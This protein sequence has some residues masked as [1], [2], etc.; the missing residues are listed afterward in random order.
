MQFLSL[1]GKANIFKAKAYYLLE[2]L[3]KLVKTDESTKPCVVLVALYVVCHF[4]C[5]LWPLAGV[6]M[7]HDLTDAHGQ[8][9]SGKDG[10]WI[11]KKENCP[12]Y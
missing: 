3:D 2:V 6:V 12:C 8:L 11:Y 9:Y 1:S 5:D 10:R 7:F 4:V